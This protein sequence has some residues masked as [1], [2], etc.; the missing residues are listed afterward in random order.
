MIRVGGKSF[1]T[2]TPKRCGKCGC[3]AFDMTRV[4]PYHAC[5][6]LISIRCA[7]CHAPKTGRIVTDGPSGSGSETYR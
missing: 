1:S 4:V 5:C 6:Y 7:I 2:A 3:H